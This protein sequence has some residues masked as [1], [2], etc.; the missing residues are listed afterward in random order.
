MKLAKILSLVIAMLM[1]CVSSVFAQS[2]QAVRKV[3]SFTFFVD[4]SGSMMMTNKEVK[5]NKTELAKEVLKR[6]NNRI[7][8]LGYAGGLHTFAPFSEVLTIAP[9]DKAKMDGAIASLKSNLDIYARF[10]PMGYG[11]DSFAPVASTMARPAAIILVTDGESNQGNDPVAEAQSVYA[12]NPNVCFH[13]ISLADTVKG[14]QV[15]DQIAALNACTVKVDAKELLTSDAAV[16]KFVADVFY[17]YGGKI[18]LRS[19]LFNFDSDVITSESAAILDEVAGMLK[20]QNNHFS[21]AGHTCN[22]GSAQY[23]MG[24][25]IRRADSVK[26]Y[27]VKQGVSS[28]KM[29]TR[30]YGLTEPKYSNATEEGRRLNRRVDIDPMNK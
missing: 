27:L 2:G 15:L 14:K 9:Y 11:I 13:I 29:T 18:V 28:D 21:I 19:V 25:S 5:L 24:L 12:A 6:V 1:L 30:G 22:I 3:D 8:D 7:P 16:D 26:R 20:A 10:T 23:N 4:Q 17:N